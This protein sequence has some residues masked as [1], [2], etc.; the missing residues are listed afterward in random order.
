M[1][2]IEGRTHEKPTLEPLI[3]VPGI[4]CEA[5]KNPETNEAYMRVEHA[6]WN[7]PVDL[8]TRNNKDSVHPL[9]STRK[10]KFRWN[11]CNIQV[12]ENGAMQLN[13]VDVSHFYTRA[14]NGVFVTVLPNADAELRHTCRYY[15]LE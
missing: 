1:P 4:L 11:A 5:R 9:G 8:L 2:D 3:P 12:Y 10:I 6:H 7:L 13:R 15:A 14:I